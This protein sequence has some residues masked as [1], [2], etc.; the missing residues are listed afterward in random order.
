MHP[1]LHPSI[2]KAKTPAAQQEKVLAHKIKE[3]M[4]GKDYKPCTNMA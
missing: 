2:A 1:P 4:L 3:K